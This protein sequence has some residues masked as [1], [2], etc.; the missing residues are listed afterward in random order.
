MAFKMKSASP[1]KGVR[2]KS[3]VERTFGNREALLLEQTNSSDEID[4]TEQFALHFLLSDQD[5]EDVNEPA[6]N[7]VVGDH[8]LSMAS[9]PQFG[10]TLRA[11]TSIESDGDNGW[12]FCSVDSPGFRRV[13]VP[14]PREDEDDEELRYSLAAMLLNARPGTPHSGESPV[15]PRGSASSS[16]PSAPL[17]WALAPSSSCFAQSDEQRA[18]A[19]KIGFMSMQGPTN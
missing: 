15:L 18:S 8:S 2:K 11:S 12:Q 14:A 13:S 1:R 10:L 16:R 3:G 17:S 6:T 19:P 9:L 7:G 5:T 4:Q